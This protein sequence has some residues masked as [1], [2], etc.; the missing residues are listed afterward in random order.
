MSTKQNYIEAIDSLVGGEI[1]LGEGDKEIAI[2]MAVK[3]HSKHRPRIVVQDFDGDGGF[4]YAISGFAS[5][6]DGFSVIKHV[7]YPVDDEDETPDI[8]Q[9]DAWMIYEKPAGKQLRFLED[10]PTSAEDFRVTYT[11]LH[12]CSYSACT[13]ESFDEEALQVL[14]AAHFCDMLATYYAQSQDG[15]IAADSV[16]HTSKSR[17]YAARAKAYRKMYFDHLGIKEGQA[18]AA[19]V[20]RDQDLK[21][22]WA[23]EKLTHKKKYR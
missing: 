17:D 18:P 6:S 1:P 14:C 12:S 19:S 3:K 7:E 23:S 13:I 2:N 22:S 21:G 9:D 11:A 15:T 4:D 20:S 10:K 16:D 5:W 8:L